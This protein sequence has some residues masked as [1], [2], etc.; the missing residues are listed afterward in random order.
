MTREPLYIQPLPVVRAAE[1]E[2][3]DP[4]QRWLIHYM[5]HEKS[6]ANGTGGAHVQGPG[7]R[8]LGSSPGPNQDLQSCNP[9]A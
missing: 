9:N 2:T 7:R 8:P 1:L 4:E 3:T 5:P 6:T